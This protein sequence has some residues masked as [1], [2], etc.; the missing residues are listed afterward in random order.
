MLCQRY[1][2]MQLAAVCSSLRNW[3]WTTPQVEEEL[4]L[5]GGL[6]GS[7]DSCELG[8]GVIA[9][10]RQQPYMRLAVQPTLECSYSW[11]HVYKAR[12]ACLIAGSLA[13]VQSHKSFVSM[14]HQAAPVSANS[15]NPAAPIGT[16]GADD[17]SRTV[18]SA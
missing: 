5:F 13:V 1:L 3:I 4:R 8:I 11:T 2:G 14:S 18:Q 16:G 9:L 17:R 15:A 7:M 12:S 6:E 10:R